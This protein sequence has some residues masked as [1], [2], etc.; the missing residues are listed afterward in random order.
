MADLWMDVDAA[1]SEVPVNIFPLLDDTDFKTIEADVN[2][3]AT[4]LSLIWHFVTTAGAY[5][6]TA[7]T[8]T[9]TGGNYDWVEQGN[10][11]FTIEI[12]ASGGAT[13]NNNTE[14]FGWFTGVATGVLPWRGPVIGFR[15][16]ALN[17]ALIDGAT[18]DVNVTAVANG[19][20]TAAAIADA[21][22]DL[23]TFAADC[24]TGSA[25]KANVETI[26]AGAI[27]AAAIAN[28]AIDFATFAADCITGTG[29]K[30]NVESISAN[31]I[32][33][34][35]INADAITSAKIADDAI[36]AEHI[37]TGAITA[38]A[39]AAD[40]IVAATLAT[41]AL[42]ADAFAAN[43]LIAASFA[44]DV[45]AEIAA[46]V[47]DEALAG[48]AGAGSA[49]EAL[50][51][52]GTAGDPW[53]TALPGAY[54]AG[55][56]GKII[57]DNIN[58]T[59]DSRATQTSVDTIDNFLDTEVAAILADTNELQVDLTNG[60]R[61]DLLIDAILEDT[62]TTLDALVKDIPTVAEF[63]ARTIAAADYTIVSDL[64]TVQTGDSFAIVNGDHGLVS[65]QDDIDA[66]LVDTG[67]D[68]PATLA[69]MVAA[70]ITNATGADVAADIIAL[71]AVADLVE[72]ILRNKMAVTDANGNTTLYA[73]NN[74]DALFTVAACL[75]DDSTTTIRKRLE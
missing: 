43:S 60:G 54:G 70:V 64:G 65:I 40:A 7:V 62:G 73:D 4:G 17:N 21:A 42:T 56:A 1:L 50:S 48:H 57:G 38:D 49:G 41:G 47:W 53:T 58:A 71:K 26:T 39:F 45:G 31:A 25:L 59:V 69:S 10:G 74:S 20:I 23:A 37:N 13:I 68:I 9:N 30:A 36:S 46:A 33:A 15:A 3:N 28:A 18:L 5:T 51:A 2:Y 72:D 61:L 6:Q 19:A 24:K 52:A 32:T 12:P 67:T 63:E 11:M 35:A 27:N 29:L 44:T 16:A 14:G 22:I 66:I 8:P 34:T 75:T 55:T